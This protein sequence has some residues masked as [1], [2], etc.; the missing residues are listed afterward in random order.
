M[1]DYE[2]K[3]LPFEGKNL[4]YLYCVSKYPTNLKEIKMPNFK[5]SIFSGFSDHTLN[6]DINIC[7]FKGAKIIE[8]HF[9]IINH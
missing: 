9:Q 5:N 2:K 3:G 1:Y 7:S 4:E 8:K 6:R